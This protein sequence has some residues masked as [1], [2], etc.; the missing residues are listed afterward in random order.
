LLCVTGY[1]IVKFTVLKED[2]GKRLQSSTTGLVS[3]LACRQAKLAVMKAACAPRRPGAETLAFDPVG[4]PASAI[5]AWA[6]LSLAMVGPCHLRVAV[7]G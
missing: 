5:G 3:D 4:V 2:E 6:A 1:L 7:E